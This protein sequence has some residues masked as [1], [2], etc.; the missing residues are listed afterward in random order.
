MEG[1]Y[2]VGNSGYLIRADL[3]VTRLEDH[4]TSRLQELGSGIDVVAREGSCYLRDIVC[5][6]VSFHKSWLKY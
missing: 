5:W 4:A 3:R 6:F 1:S 2:L